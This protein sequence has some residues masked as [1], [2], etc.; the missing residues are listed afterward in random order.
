MIKIQNLYYSGFWHGGRLMEARKNMYTIYHK[1][2]Q[3]KPEPPPL[4][5]ARCPTL[6]LKQRK[7][8]RKNPKS[9]W[10]IKSTMA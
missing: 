4:F 3:L 1:I 5:F 2:F 6:D 8:L 9:L 10:G 7:V